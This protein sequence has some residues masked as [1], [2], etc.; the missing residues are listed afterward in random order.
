MLEIVDIRDATDEEIKEYTRKQESPEWQQQ[1]T[2]I[3]VMNKLSKQERRSMETKYRVWD[4]D[5]KEYLSAGKVFIGIC[6]GK[7]PEQS[8]IYL[9]LIDKTKISIKTDS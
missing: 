2:V 3:D 6:P 4:K 9:D 5:R 7:M 1:G 8:E